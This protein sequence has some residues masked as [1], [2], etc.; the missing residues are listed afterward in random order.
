MDNVVVIGAGPTGL[1]AA[2]GLREAGVEVRVLARRC[3][4]LGDVAGA[5]PATAR[6]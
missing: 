1:A 5:G 2:C 3:G 4:P 6:G